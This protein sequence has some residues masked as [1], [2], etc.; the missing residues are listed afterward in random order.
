MYP[1]PSICNA[2][3]YEHKNIPKVIK[4]PLKPLMDCFYM[5]KNGNT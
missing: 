4:T 2:E 1:M 5:L 3:N